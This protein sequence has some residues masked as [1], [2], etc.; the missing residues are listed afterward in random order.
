MG[1]AGEIAAACSSMAI[2]AGV[3]TLV[4]MSAS[5]DSPVSCPGELLISALGRASSL[6]ANAADMA[7]KCR[8]LC[9][10]EAVLQLSMAAGMDIPEKASSLRDACLPAVLNTVLLLCGRTERNTT[11]H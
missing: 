4:V 7:L 8:A 1:G 11:P 9:A 10:C 5:S 2:T 3:V 6:A